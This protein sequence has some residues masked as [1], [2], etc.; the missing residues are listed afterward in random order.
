MNFDRQ[1]P[2]RG[3]KYDQ[4]LEGARDV[5]LS[6]GFSGANVDDIARAAGVS[7]ATLYSYFADKRMMFNEVV[8]TECD[9]MNERLASE[10]D[11]SM[12]V[13]DVLLH[14]AS[15]LLRFLLSPPTMQLFRICVAESESFPELGHAFYQSGPVEGKD[16]LC[17]FL[18]CATQQGLL[19]ID[20]VQMA[21]DQ[22]SELCKAR[23]FLRATFGVQSVF[24]EEEIDWVAREAVTTFW[25]RYGVLDARVIRP[26]ETSE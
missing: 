9:R 10:I 4:V 22:F 25:A 15:G 2:K 20:D 17:E 24:S 26:E 11:D 6:D 14:A 16:R 8:R 21:S 3:R 12:K 18:T 5:F 23:L 7:K 1:I 19:A 13:R